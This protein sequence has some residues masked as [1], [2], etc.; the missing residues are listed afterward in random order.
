MSKPDHFV[1][2]ERVLNA[3]AEDLYA[4]WTEPEVMAAWMGGDVE[5]DV[6]PGGAYRIAV[7]GPEGETYVH[8]GEYRALEPGRRI[9]Q[10]FRTSGIE[11]LEGPLPY[12]DEF[13]EVRLQPLG[14]AQTLLILLNGWNGEAMPDEAK[15]AVKQAWSA[16]IDQLEALF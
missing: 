3:A 10:T 16:W 15:A 1:Q 8:S 6:R 13:I 12:S 11:G 14:P 9:V 7:R 2:V 5:A 4:A